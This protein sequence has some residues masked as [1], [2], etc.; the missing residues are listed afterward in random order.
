MSSALMP[1]ALRAAVILAMMTSFDD[2]ATFATSLWVKTPKLMR[3]IVGLTVTFPVPVTLTVGTTVD[4]SSA[5]TS[6]L[7]P[8]AGEKAMTAAMAMIAI[9]CKAMNATLF[10]MEYL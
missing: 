1:A 2:W 3:A 10:F 7:A 5:L 9:D 6:C 4:V 8:R